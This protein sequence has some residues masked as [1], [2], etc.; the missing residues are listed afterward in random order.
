MYQAVGPQWVRFGAPRRK[1]D[2]HSVVLDGNIAQELVDDFREFTESSKWCVFR[3]VMN[4]FPVI[5][6]FLKLIPT[7]SGTLTEGSPIGVD[8]YFTALPELERVVS[9]RPW[10]AISVI[11]FVCFH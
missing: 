8:I 5:F 3:F 7:F 11:V 2:V 4:S 6:F 10:Q 9:S 1:R